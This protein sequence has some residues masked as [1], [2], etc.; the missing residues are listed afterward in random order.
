MPISGRHSYGKTL[1]K[2]TKS[3]VDYFLTG[4][5]V[6]PQ[7]SH[8]FGGGRPPGIWRVNSLASG[9]LIMKYWRHVP[10]ASGGRR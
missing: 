6:Y 4:L 2:Q 10:L 9:G 8:L 5:V 7:T 1:G 3:K